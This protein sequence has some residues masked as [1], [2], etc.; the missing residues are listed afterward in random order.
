MSIELPK[1]QKPDLPVPF[2]Y[3]TN[4]WAIRSESPDEVAEAIHLMGRHQANWENGIEHAFEGHPF[5]APPLMGWILLVGVPLVPVNPFKQRESEK[6]TEEE[7]SK[8]FMLSERFGEVQAFG[9]HRVVGYCLWA[10]AVNGQLHRGFGYL[11]ER[12]ETWWNE[13]DTATED[14]LGL[15]F[16]DENSPEA[17]SE[18]GEI[19]ESYFERED[20]DFPDEEHVIQMAAAWS[21]NPLELDQIE[22]VSPAFGILGSGSKLLD[23]DLV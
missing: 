2:G 22:G 13:G 11:G 1:K 10:K 16:I 17:T 3:K 4:W 9:S 15:K 6:P 19:R 14:E 21:L 7:L 20:L 12:G 23:P 8:M 5:V 18:D